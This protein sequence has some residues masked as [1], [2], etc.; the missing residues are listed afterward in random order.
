M[1]VE[2][3][4]DKMPDGTYRYEHCDYCNYDLHTCGGC[5]TPLSHNG[6]ERINGVW[7]KHPVCF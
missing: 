3:S 7:Q 4:R 2:L 1:D 5:G 6:L